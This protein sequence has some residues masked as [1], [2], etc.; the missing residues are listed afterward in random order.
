M[1]HTPCD[2]LWL[3]L[4]GP[5]WQRALSAYQIILLRITNLRVPWNVLSRSALMSYGSN[6]RLCEGFLLAL[7][8][9][10][11]IKSLSFV[12]PYVFAVWIIQASNCEIFFLQ[13]IKIEPPNL[14]FNT[15]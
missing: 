15:R 14:E 7:H 13:T 8:D 3:V 2:K 10:V 9:V 12:S 5:S 4:R 6:L 11:E 1:Y